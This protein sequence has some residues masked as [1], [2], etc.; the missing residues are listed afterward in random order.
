MVAVRNNYLF[1][2]WKA[3]ENNW[4]RT[5]MDRPVLNFR[6]S[7]MREKSPVRIWVLTLFGLLILF[8]GMAHAQLGDEGSLIITVQDKTGAVIPQAQLA[9]RNLATDTVQ[10]ATTLS[11]GGYTFPAVMAGRYE[12][13]VSK[14]GFRNLVFKMIEVNASRVTDLTAVLQIGEVSQQVVVQSSQTPLLQTSSNTLGVTISRKDL[15]DL[16]M[17]GRNVA[18]FARLDPGRAGGTWDNL[19]GDAQV[20][21]MDG[22][23][24]GSS[25]FKLYGGEINYQVVSP[26]LQNVQELTVQTSGLASNQGYGQ[27]SMQAVFDTRSGTNHFHGRV[28]ADLENSSFDANGYENDYFGIPKP[29][30]HKDDFGGSIGGPILKNKLF[31]F[32]SYEADLIPGSIVAWNSFMTPALQQG[33]YTYLGTDGQTHTVN[34]FQLAAAGGIQST[35]DTGIAAELAKINSSLSYGTIGNVAGENDQ[36]AQNVKQINF[37]EPNNQYFY[38][39]TFRIDYVINPKLRADFAFNQTKVSQPTSLPPA[40]PGPAFQYQQDGYKSNAYSAALGLDWTISPTLLNQFQGGYLYNWSLSAYKSAAAHLYEKHSI[41]FWVAP[42]GLNVSGPTGAAASGDFFYS[43]ISNFYPAISFSDNLI[44]QHSRHTFTFGGS[45]YQEQDHYWNP[46]LGYNNVVMGLGPGDPAY[47]VFSST[48]P[49]LATASGG[50]IGTMQAYYAVLTGDIN[51][52]GGSHPLNTS[53]HTYSKYGGVNL[54]ELQRAWGLYFQD[55]WRV[56]KNLT[57]NYG[58]R[59]DFT[60]DD[61][62]LNGVYYSPTPAGLWGPSGLNNAFNPGSFK[63][64]A[65]PSYHAHVHA[66]SPWNVSPQPNFGFAWLPTGKGVLGRLLGNGSTVIRGGFSL[67][68]YTPQ[69]QTFWTYASNYGSFFYQNFDYTANNTAVPGYF[70]SGTFH[71]SD[72]LNGDLPP[73]PSGW[74]VSP[75]SY[76]S[77]ISESSV[78]DQSPFI[79]M[80]PKIK[81]PYVE[82]WNFGFQRRLGRKNVLEVRYVGDRALHQWMP[83]NLNEV[84]IFENGFLKQFKQAQANL[85]ANGGTSFQGAPGSTPLFD[86]AFSNDPTAGYTYGGFIYE[87]EHGQVGTMAAQLSTPFGIT[88]QYFCNLVSS[89]FGPCANLWGYSGA[90]GSYPTNIFQAN[91]YAAGQGVNYLTSAGYSDYNALQV[92][93]RQQDWHGMQFNVDWTWSRSLGLGTNQ[94]PDYTMRNLRLGYGP[95]GSDIHQIIRIF[96]TYQLPIGRGKALLS[97]DALLDRVVGGWTVG[98]ITDFHSGAPFQMI[99]GNDTYNNQFDGGI[100]LHGVNNKQ[101]QH[102]VGLYKVPGGPSYERYWI[103]PK[104]IAKNGEANSTY[105]SPNS[106][107][108]SVGT[109]YWLWGIGHWNTDLSLSK[110]IPIRGAMQFRLQGEA[111]NA[112]NHPSW[113]TG[114][115]GLQD[116]TFGTTFFP[117]GHRTLEVRGDFQF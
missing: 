20:S 19:S 95:T 80:N 26:R 112:F 58:L 31:Y 56:R 100:V 24:A 35:M 84:N 27:A 51:I 79:G 1:Q 3:A 9:L 46:P 63:G 81:Q 45:F 11:A 6:R 82:S 37:L 8:T 90:G 102:A 60:G 38:Y 104:Y 17:T 7:Q 64:S 107:P 83:I 87:L 28:F 4:H 72:Y 113:N 97:H 74:Q 40:F 61:H 98:T 57:L 13:T 114:D 69:Y 2:A 86:Q 76:S 101:L 68:R 111:L 30:Y 54:D 99:G 21:T 94:A 48:N 108:G 41:V 25:R 33:N 67:R 10:R 47:N 55:S 115:S 70:K 91:P 109:R 75:E 43:G 96:G 29:V 49:A 39:P 89:S 52:V 93:L 44:W 92:M 42:W 34:L 71:Y 32:G 110:T 78:A 12:L 106:T 85:T 117:H 66:Y 73:Y 105:I 23:V 15:E 88:G 18:Q 62:D 22:I 103:N 65:D 53:T 16:P 36:E 116:S 14:A 59:W 50:E 5:G 77:T